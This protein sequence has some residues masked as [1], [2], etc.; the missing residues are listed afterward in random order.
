MCKTLTRP[1]IGSRS[2]S[3]Y[4]LAEHGAARRCVLP[5]DNYGPELVSRPRAFQL[6][7][8]FSYSLSQGVVLDAV[9]G[10]MPPRDQQVPREIHVR[11]IHKCRTIDPARRWSPSRYPRRRVLKNKRRQVRVFTVSL[12]AKREIP[13]PEIH[14]TGR[15]R[16]AVTSEGYDR[17]RRDR[18][19]PPR[20]EP[21][22]S[23]RVLSNRR[24]RHTWPPRIRLARVTRWW[25]PFGGGSASAMEMRTGECLRGS[26]RHAG[27]KPRHVASPFWFHRCDS[28]C[29]KKIIEIPRVFCKGGD[30]IFNFK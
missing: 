20:R 29:K 10:S 7:P 8:Y 27:F 30:A 4:M 28:P 24:R 19:T 14:A 2:Y 26:R 23:A 13:I 16:S 12:A 11:E 3:A 5:A 25:T 18:W 17:A 1:S 22:I 15:T 21:G 9:D 6:G